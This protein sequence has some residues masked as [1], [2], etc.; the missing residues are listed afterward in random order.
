MKQFRKAFF[1]FAEREIGDFLKSQDVPSAIVF[2]EEKFY[3]SLRNLPIS[4][5]AKHMLIVGTTGSGKTTAIDLFLQSIAPRFRDEKKPEQLIFFDGKN[6]A[7]PLLSSLGYKPDDPDVWILNPCDNRSAVWDIARDARSPLLARNIASLLIPEEPNSTAPFFANASR[8][9]VYAVLLGL[10]EIDSKGADEKPPWNLRDLLC[11]LDSEEN[12]RKVASHHPRGLRI[13]S[14]ILNDAQHSMGV[15]SHVSTKIAKFEQVAALWHTLSRDRFFRISEF[16]DRPGVLIIGDDPKLRESLWPLTA[17]L[18]KALGEEILRRPNTKKPDTPRH[19]FVLDEFRAMEKV[20]FVYELLNRGRS[21]GVSVLIGAQSVSG[22][23]D[24]YGDFRANDILGLCSTKCFLRV[25]DPGTDEWI[26]DFLGE[27]RNFRPTYSETYGG[28]DG[29]SSQ[30]QQKEEDRGIFVKG[31]FT[32]LPMPGSTNRYLMVSDVPLL[33]QTMITEMPLSLVQSWRTP[34]DQTPAVEPRDAMDEHLWPWIPAE[35]A[36]FTRP[37]RDR[38]DGSGVET[39]SAEGG[40][41]SPKG[42]E[43]PDSVQKTEGGETPNNSGVPSKTT[44][45]ESED[46]KEEPGG[47]APPQAGPLAPPPSEP[48][49]PTDLPKKGKNKND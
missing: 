2:N 25:G 12:I 33:G 14:N 30:C 1:S 32:N 37:Q 7:V 31:Y 13:V 26:R 43:A 3:W 15:I 17:L 38:A 11:A 5:A 19:W 42:E 20:D 22:I 45:P 47:A 21:K 28:N 27:D 16:L 24:V 29:G 8:D 40:A 49:N 35:E 36:F 6:E 44:P 10:S 4:E 39:K 34:R 9:L 48:V 23:K 46:K 18:L 41:T